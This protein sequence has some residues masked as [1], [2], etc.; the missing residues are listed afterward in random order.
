MEEEDGDVTRS[1]LRHGRSYK[2]GS[3][4][5]TAEAVFEGVCWVGQ[6]AQNASVPRNLG[7]PPVIG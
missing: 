2:R 1:R 5:G 7:K 6:S 4:S 3:P